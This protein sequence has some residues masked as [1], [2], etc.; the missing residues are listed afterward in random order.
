MRNTFLNLFEEKISQLSFL[1][2]EKVIDLME[3][4]YKLGKESSDEKY[5]QL[6]KTFEELLD[7][8]G[9]YGKYNSSRNHMEESWKEQAGLL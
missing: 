7:L 8:Y 3:I 6:K 9:D 2:R 4:T 1:D 5:N